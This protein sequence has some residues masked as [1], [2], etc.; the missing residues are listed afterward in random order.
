MKAVQI[1][2]YIPLQD[3]DVKSNIDKP[4]AQAGQLLIEV[5]AAG[6][7]PID[8][9]ICEGHVKS[10]FDLPFPIILGKD[11]SGIVQA[12]GTG[13]SDFKAGDEVY[14][15]SMIF[16]H[17]TGSFAEFINV[18]P[19]GIAPKPKSLS[20]LEAAALPLAGVSAWQ[21]LVDF[22]HLQ[23][24]Q[25]IL[26]HGG[27]GGIGSL[28]IQIAKDLGAYVATTVSKDN[29][30][31]AKA[32]GADEA[33]DYKNQ[34]FETVLKDY[35][36]VFDTVGGDTYERSYK[37]LKKGGVIVSM[38]EPP[39]EELMKQYGVKA[40]LE[41]TDVNHSRLQKLSELVDHDRLNIRIDKTFPL[42]KAREALLHLK[43]GHPRG[44]VVI[45]IK[46]T[47]SDH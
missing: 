39:R 28:A 43:T 21:A 33:I 23:K 24:G 25:K 4:S 7:N 47:G 40:F 27:T 11:F 35:D 19:N 10:R 14:G 32:L 42:D 29:I 41:F 2:Q 46:D 45:K 16:H 18:D 6:V 1:N 38:L 3:V 9:K 34:A 26:I 37:V 15:E 36:A 31:H 17:G 30:E 12:V 20:H 22:M 13:V 44:K 5:Q 8:W